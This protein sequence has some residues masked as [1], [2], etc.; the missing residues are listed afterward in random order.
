MFLFVQNFGENTIFV[1]FIIRILNRNIF[2]IDFQGERIHL[3]PIGQ[4]L[5]TQTVN[6][7]TIHFRPGAVRHI[8][9]LYELKQENI[10]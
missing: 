1:I 5:A 7:N 6:D 4:K 9:R 2:W 3:C 10:K 8:L